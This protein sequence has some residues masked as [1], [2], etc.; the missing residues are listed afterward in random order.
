M[1]RTQRCQGLVIIS[2]RGNRDGGARN[3]AGGI[4]A[5]GLGGEMATY[6]ERAEDVVTGNLHRSGEYVMANGAVVNF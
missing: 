3:T 1:E 2:K 6:A 5:S 4:W